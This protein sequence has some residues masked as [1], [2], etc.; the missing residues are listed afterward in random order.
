MTIDKL[1]RLINDR[2]GIAS[3]NDMQ[4]AMA[5]DRSRATILLAPTGSGKT[6]AFA[7]PLLMAA[8]ASTGKPQAVVIAP[9]RE[10]VL[11]IADVVRPL[12]LPL[13][14]TPLYGGHSMTDETRS[15]EGGT[16]IIVAT[17]GRL[18]DHLNRSLIDLS[19]VKTL[20]LDEYDKS[21]EL[22]FSDEMR[23]VGRRLG[24]LDKIILTSATRLSQM[25][26]YLP[27][28]TPTLID[29]TRQIPAPSARMDIVE[30][31][32]PS[33]DKLDTMLNLAAS[34]PSGSRAIIFVNHRDAAERVHQA[35]TRA[36][37]PAGLYHGGLDQLRRELAVDLLNNGTTPL[38]VSTDLASRGLDITDV[39]AVVH[40][41][42]PP[43]AE[44]WTHRNGRTARQDASGTV[45]VITAEGENIPDYVDWQRR[46]VPP[47]MDRRPEPSA[48]TTLYFN[49]GKREKISRGDI[50][51]FLMARANLS[52]LEVSGIVVKDH[53]AIAAVPAAKADTIL[54]AI[55]PHKIKN[56]RLRVSRLA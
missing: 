42:L 44:S 28:G 31:P 10:L 47:V 24:R 18:L 40:Y 41:H 15:I 55:A 50:A 22:G 19:G 8:T 7:L 39:Q 51:G 33:R 16:D 11:Q 23:R 6:I 54:A 3:L 12:A 46:Y 17:P 14:T 38:L 21:L 32:S 48:L 56:R 27:L 36:G 43:S 49:G 52:A 2:H 29:F 53:C 13:K 37:F 5:D 4:Q 35:M 30:V 26:D 9:S 1:T 20:V 45:Y 25:P 34:L